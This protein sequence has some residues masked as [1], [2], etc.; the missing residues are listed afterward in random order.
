MPNY[1]ISDHAVCAVCNQGNTST[2]SKLRSVEYNSVKANVSFCYRVCDYCGSETIDQEQ[3]LWNRREINRFKKRVE[4]IPLGSAILAMRK[5]SGLTQ[6]QMG[7]LLGGGPVAFSKYEHD[8][9]IPDEAMTNLL[10]LAIADPTLIK[11]LQT[12]KSEYVTVTSSPAGHWTYGP[13]VA[14]DV[15]ADETFQFFGAKQHLNPPSSEETWQ[16]ITQ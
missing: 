14:D 11:Q 1:T 9:L 8:D 7:A 4:H 3:S 13:G 6:P 2:V 16:L 10:R 15:E 12:L 5:R